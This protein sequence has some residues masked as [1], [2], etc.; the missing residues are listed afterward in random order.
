MPRV[1]AM[2]TVISFFLFSL[3][4]ISASGADDPV[5]LFEKLIR[6]A[7]RE[8]STSQPVYLNKHKQAWAKR[9]FFTSDIKYD[10]KKTDSL[11]SPIIG[12]VTF[13][14][15]T[16]QTELFPTRDQ[17]ETASTF[18]ST[19]SPF[20]V[21]MTYAYRGSAWSLST[22]SYEFLSGA[23]GGKS[24]DLAEEIIRK[25]SAAIPM[26]ALIYWLPK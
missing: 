25:E 2:V 20:R 11:V 13:H 18:K 26:A 17:A 12:I 9:R 10:V 1:S 15:I 6:D 21:S 22:G 5:A 3:V 23:L 8:T 16:E 19:S 7:Q 4:S 14:L 24:L